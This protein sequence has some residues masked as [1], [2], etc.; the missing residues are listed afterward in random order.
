VTIAQLSEDKPEAA[1]FVELK[2]IDRVA[3]IR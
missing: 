3:A 2:G 1:G